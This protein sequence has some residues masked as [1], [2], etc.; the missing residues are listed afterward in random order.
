MLWN[1]SWAFALPWYMWCR[2][3]PKTVLSHESSLL[4]L[5]RF[6]AEMSHREP[7]EMKEFEHNDLRKHM[8][9]QKHCHHDFDFSVI[10]HVQWIWTCF[11]SGFAIDAHSALNEVI[12]CFKPLSLQVWALILEKAMAKFVGSYAHLSGGTF[13]ICQS[14]WAMD[15]EWDTSQRKLEDWLLFSQ[16]GFRY[17]VIWYPLAKLRRAIFV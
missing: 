11:Q 6:G 1:D 16:C 3:D 4:F 8:N 5:C 12:E 7:K 13:G 9:R 17:G 15:R 10:R 2:V 14:S